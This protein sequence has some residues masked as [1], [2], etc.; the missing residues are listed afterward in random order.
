MDQ[1]ALQHSC[2]CAHSVLPDGSTTECD[3]VL[4]CRGILGEKDCDSVW[5][6]NCDCT[7][8]HCFVFDML[9]DM[10]S[11]SL[12]ICFQEVKRP[13]TQVFLYSHF[14]F[15][16]FLSSQLGFVI[17]YCIFV[18]YMVY[19][20]RRLTGGRERGGGGGKCTDVWTSRNKKQSDET[21][22]PK[23]TGGGSKG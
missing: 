11:V 2:S 9:I 3:A 6:C 4:M 8:V 12:L 5:I 19:L 20:L 14:L 22:N 13:L 21:H 18:Y 1:N 7:F 16:Y 10:F 15:R 17:I 23:Y